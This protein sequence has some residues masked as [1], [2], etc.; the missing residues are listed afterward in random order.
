MNQLA[1]LADIFNASNL[2]WWINCGTLL[3]LVRQG[4][5]LDTDSDIDI[6]CWAQSEGWSDL[7]VHLREAGYRVRALAYRGMVYKLWMRRPPHNG[8]QRRVG[9]RF[10]DLHIFRRHGEVA[11]YPAKTVLPNPPED[12]VLRRAILSSLG[13]PLRFVWRRTSLLDSEAPALRSVML[14]LGFSLN[15][16]EVPAYFYDEIKRQNLAGIRLPVPSL[17]EKM[18]TYRYG[19]WRTPVD[20]WDYRR[21]DPTLQDHA[22]PQLPPTPPYSR[23][24]LTG[25][26]R[27]VM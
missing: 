16:V 18:L 9:E 12:H 15:T 5:L 23:G 8:A 20:D 14:S 26:F 4:Q 3:G 1:E 22:P 13:P 6:E 24:L 21:D 10:V 17:T 2:R 7:M 19:D 27:Q 11:W 25:P